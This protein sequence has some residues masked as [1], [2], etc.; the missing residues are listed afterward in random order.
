M[1]LEVLLDPVSTRCGHSFCRECL[2]KVEGR[3]RGVGKCP[4]CRAPVPKELPTPNVIIRTMLEQQCPVAVRRRRE[5]AEAETRRVAAKAA[6][7][8]AF[9]ARDAAELLPLAEAAVAAD[10]VEA[11]RAQLIRAAQEAEPDAVR[12][13]YLAAVARDNDRARAEAVRGALR[14][15]PNGA[16]DAALDDVG[17][18]GLIVGARDGEAEVVRVLLEGGADVDKARTDNGATPLYMAAEN[19][20]EAVVRLLVERGADVDKAR[21]DSGATPLHIAAQN[22]HEAVVR[23]L[24]EGGADVDKARTDDGATPLQAATQSGCESVVQLLRA[25]ATARRGPQAM[26]GSAKRRRAA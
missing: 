13:M 17:R 5:R 20:H 8:R 24:V 26:Q 19:G 1:C 23:V 14:G 4:M 22:G 2:R 25:A 11:V 7:K 21:T 12:R 18:T 9:E 6:M 16:A 15:A 3:K 10:D